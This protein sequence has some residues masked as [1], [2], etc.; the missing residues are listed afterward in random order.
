MLK[1]HRIHRER[2]L[3]LKNPTAS[4][5]ETLKTTSFS[6]TLESWQKIVALDSHKKSEHVENVSV[7]K[8]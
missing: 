1:V 5:L 2:E 8:N 3:V 4:N 6:S 7:I